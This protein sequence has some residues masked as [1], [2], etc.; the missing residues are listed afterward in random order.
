MVKSDVLVENCEIFIS[1]L[2]LAPLQGVTP[3]E[4]HEDVRY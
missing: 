1:H 4:F 3:S 2:Y